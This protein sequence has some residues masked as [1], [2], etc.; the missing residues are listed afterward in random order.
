M[1]I[2]GEKNEG[3]N[4]FTYNKKIN[5]SIYSCETIAWKI[6]FPCFYFNKKDVY[7]QV[8]STKLFLFFI[9]IFAKNIN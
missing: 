5:Y 8:F 7:N 4:T 9:I 2:N 1:F 6:I 3:I